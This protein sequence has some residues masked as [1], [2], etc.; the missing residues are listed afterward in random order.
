M[1][2]MSET[3][4]YRELCKA[5]QPGLLLTVNES[6]PTAVAYD[7]MVVVH[8]DEEM[9]TV[10]LTGRND[11]SYRIFHDSDQPGTRIEAVDDEGS[12]GREHQVTTIEVIGVA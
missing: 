12:G 10:T 5:M 1:Q 11:S 7:E 2:T 4:H 3:D 8:V 6:D 9:G